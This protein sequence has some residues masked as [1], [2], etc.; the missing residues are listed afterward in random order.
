MQIAQHDKSFEAVTYSYLSNIFY[1]KA[2]AVGTFNMHTG[3]VLLQEGKLL[4]LRNGFSGVCTMTCFLQY[5]KYGGEEFLE[6][7][8]VSMTV[9]DSAN[10]GRGKVLLRKVQTSMFYEEP[11][12]M[13]REKEL[14][15][16]AT[17][18]AAPPKAPA[19]TAGTTPKIG[20]STAPKVAGSAPPKVGAKGSTP[21]RKPP[22]LAAVP[23]RPHPAHRPDSAVASAPMIRATLPERGVREL[24]ADTGTDMSRKFPN[25]TP[26]ALL[27][28]SN[29]LIRALTVNTKD[30]IDA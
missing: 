8:F 15:D 29:P 7:K 25:I 2:A 4:E 6:G 5:F 10:C 17:V 26:H 28:R 19:A 11:F 3:K 16:S 24:P 27:T 12:V 9:K 30:L 1:A 22:L 20:G 14:K 18:K 13:K 23:K 21:A